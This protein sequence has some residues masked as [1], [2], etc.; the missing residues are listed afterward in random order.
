MTHGS[1]HQISQRFSLFNFVATIRKIILIEINRI[2]NKTQV[3][4]QIR[5][6]ELLAV[7]FIVDSHGSFFIV[8][9]YDCIEILKPLFFILTQLF[10]INIDFFV[11]FLYYHLVSIIGCSSY[12]FFS[13][14]LFIFIVVFLTLFVSFIGVSIY[15]FEYLGG[16]VFLFLRH[17]F[18]T[19]FRTVHFNRDNHTSRGF[20]RIK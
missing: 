2:R 8:T 7:T 19:E 20:K 4:G 17:H 6:F 1:I 11:A 5:L 15:F 10:A 9:L 16:S 13:S 3:Y 18:F 12:N 14:F